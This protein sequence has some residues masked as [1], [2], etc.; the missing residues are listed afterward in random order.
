MEAHHFLKVDQFLRVVGVPLV[1]EGHVLEETTER[2]SA[3]T[4]PKPHLE[5]ASVT[6]EQQR[7]EGDVKGPQLGHRQP[8][9]PVV[10]GWVLEGAAEQR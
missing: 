5:A 7:H 10:A 6:F 3:R 9:G 4:M 8:V 2:R 1:D